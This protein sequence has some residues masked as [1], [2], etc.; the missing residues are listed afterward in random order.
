MLQRDIAIY[1]PAESVFI[2]ST[3]QDISIYQCRLTSLVISRVCIKDGLYSNAP[4]TIKLKNI[5]SI[6]AV[7]LYYNSELLSFKFN[8]FMAASITI[9]LIHIMLN[10]SF[11]PSHTAY[12]MDSS[13]QL[14]GLSYHST[15]RLDNTPTH[16]CHDIANF[17]S[18]WA[19][20]LISRLCLI[21]LR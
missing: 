7:Y 8:L 1:R 20:F 12:T 4:G 11:L 14:K 5:I 16:H 15:H 17:P 13:G 19:R 18:V 21:L 10:E 3:S 2:S 6:L 9:R